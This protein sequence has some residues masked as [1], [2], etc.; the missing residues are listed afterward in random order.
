MYLKL[1]LADKKSII[2]R[3][4]LCA[5]LTISCNKSENY[6]HSSC[7]P[8]RGWEGKQL[9]LPAFKFK[10]LNYKLFSFVIPFNSFYEIYRIYVYFVFQ[11]TIWNNN[12]FQILTTFY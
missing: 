6:D 1:A 11:Q 7:K 9:N 5:L 12:L 4:R 3:W 10:N 2:H 8:L